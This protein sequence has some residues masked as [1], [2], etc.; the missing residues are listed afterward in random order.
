MSGSDN[1]N[2]PNSETTEIT[3]IIE[4]I[5]PINDEI[6][7]ER[8]SFKDKIKDILS[9]AKTEVKNATL[10]AKMLVGSLVAM[11]IYEYGPGNETVTPLITGPVIDSVNGIGGLALTTTI[12]AGSVISQQLCAG[13]LSRKVISSFPEVTDTIYK[14]ISDDGDEFI[15]YRE[16][17]RSHRISNAFFLGS[18][19]NVLREA[20]IKEEKNEN[21]LKSIS[22]SS[23]FIS[24]SAVGA[25]AFSV[26]LINQTF[27]ENSSVQF[28]IDV[29]SHPALWISLGVGAVALDVFKSK[30]D[31]N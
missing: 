30:K 17:P 10:G 12:A 13:Y 23:A 25:T 5:L 24:G 2:I 31:K 21:E 19:Y 16:L 1:F 7:T 6:K 11:T 9:T 4:P 26:D 3:N 8:L 22:R 15:G 14:H 27:P 18:T 28:G 20:A 29:I